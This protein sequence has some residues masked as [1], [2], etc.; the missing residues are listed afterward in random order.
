[1]ACASLPSFW[2]V[3]CYSPKG[4]TEVTSEDWPERAPRLL[5]RRQVEARPQTLQ[6]VTETALAQRF[7]PQAMAAAHISPTSLWSR[8]RQEAWQ[9]PWQSHSDLQDFLASAEQQG[10]G[11]LI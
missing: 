2:A 10:A 6:S 3:R 1:M 11:G 9:L 4:G 5:N 7:N 8:S